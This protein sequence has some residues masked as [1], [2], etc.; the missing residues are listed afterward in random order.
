[1]LMGSSSVGKTAVVERIIT[2]S[3][4]DTNNPTVGVQYYDIPIDLGNDQVSVQL[5]DTAGQE[6][7][8]ALCKTYMRNANGI[9][10]IYDISN[11]QSFKDLPDWA[12][13]ISTCCDANTPVLLAGNKIDEPMFREISYEEGA[14]FAKEH[15]YEFIEVSA[16]TGENVTE[17]LMKLAKLAFDQNPSLVITTPTPEEESGGCCS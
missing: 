10:L 14:G 17:G 6:K 13:E 8:R 12:D 3:F 4:L 5:W 7:Y 16:K 15:G 2:D 11:I 1:M 9:F